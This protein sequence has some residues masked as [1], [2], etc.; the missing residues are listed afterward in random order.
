MAVECDLL[1][2]TAPVG[3]LQLDRAPDPLMP[4]HELVAIPVDLGELKQGD[5]KLEMMTNTHA[6][7]IFGVLIANAELIVNVK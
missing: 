5:N 3:A 2:L 1:G 6:D 4:E 7:S